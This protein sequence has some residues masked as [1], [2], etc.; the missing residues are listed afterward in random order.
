MKRKLLSILMLTGLLALFN[1]S[2]AQVRYINEIF[3]SV[4]RTVN[5]PY[6]T[7]VAVNLLFGNTQVPPPLSGSPLWSEN[8]ICDIYTPPTSDAVTNRPVI[9]LAHTGSYLPAIINNQV[10][11][12]KNDSAIVAIATSFAKRGYVVVAPNYRLGWNPT[13]TNQEAATEQ[14]L[15]ATYR[16]MQDIR[17]CIRFIRTNAATYRVDTSKIIVGG[18]GTGGYIAYGLGS[19]NNRNDIEGSLKFLRG[20]ASP[21]VNVDTLGDWNGLGG[22]PTFNIAGS[23]SVSA[24]AHMTFNYGGAMGDTLWIDNQSLPHVG[25]HC[26]GDIFAPYKTGNVVVPTTGVTVIPNASGAGAVVP[27][28]NR[29]GINNKMNTMFSN[30][31][32]SKNAL[33]YTNGENNLFPIR[34]PFPVEGSPW[35]FWDRPTVRAITSAP[36]RGVP[37]PANGRNADSISMLTNPLMTESRGRLYCD[38]I[39][40]FIAPRIALQF[41]LAATYELANFSLASPANNASV[42]IFDDPTKNVVIRWNKSSNSSGSTINYV[43]S[44]DLPGGKFLTPLVDVDAGNDTDSLVL[45]MDD[46]YAGLTDLGF[47]VDQTATV[48]WTITASNDVFYRLADRRTVSLTKRA[49]VGLK[50]NNISAFVNVYPNPAKDNLSVSIDKGIA[51]IANIEII[52]I[53]GRRVLSLEGLNTHQQNIALSTFGTGVYIL[54]VVSTNG[55]SAS[56]KFIVQ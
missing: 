36:Y 39:V 6:D 2:S 26:V 45:P 24:A 27:S 38:T 44:I 16:G 7:N 8:L 25:L 56:K 51:A 54:N 42:D 18:Q 46:V 49:P 32:V 22:L 55:A 35:E 34:T 40:R 10:T 31:E 47:G 19:V 43:W 33:L 4:N 3:T 29:R 48:D 17:N 52:D 53:T 50:D 41:G 13:T 11:G 12:N 14:L 20:N 9:I 5:V 15:K 37:L 1:Q 30:D 28:F 21:M 23:S